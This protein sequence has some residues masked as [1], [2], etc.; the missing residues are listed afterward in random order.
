MATA[1]P[2]ELC[3][4][5]ILRDWFRASLLQELEE[6]ILG[7]VSKKPSNLVEEVQQLLVVR[8]KSVGH[9]SP[10]FHEE[11]SAPIR[12]KC[13]RS[14]DGSNEGHKALLEL[15]LRDRR[16]PL[17]VFIH[18]HNLIDKDADLY[19]NVLIIDHDLLSPHTL[20]TGRHEHS[21]PFSCPLP[22]ANISHNMGKNEELPI[23]RGLY[24]FVPSCA[25]LVECSL[26]L[27][28][29]LFG[30]IVSA[31]LEQHDLALD[32]GCHRP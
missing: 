9:V 14:G 28:E 3:S 25:Y 7:L 21:S 31:Y 12:L 5:E 13:F 30:W 17:I 23:R 11:G 24:P 4:V 29:L 6:I 22:P 19:R 8:W 26:H 18:P 2:I 10:L 32:L 16:P 27:D 1:L 15:G 20:C